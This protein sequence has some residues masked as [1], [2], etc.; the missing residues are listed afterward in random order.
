MIWY[1]I[2]YGSF[3][4]INS[5]LNIMTQ[6]TTFLFISQWNYY[7]AKWEHNGVHEKYYALQ[8]IKVEI[9]PC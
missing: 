8:F 6:Y 2:E 1:G 3:C 7:K 9:V 4:G 5:E